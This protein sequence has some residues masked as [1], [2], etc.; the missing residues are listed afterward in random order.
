[1]SAFFCYRNEP[2]IVDEPFRSTSLSLPP[3]RGRADR[4]GIGDM[5]LLTRRCGE[6]N[7]RPEA[8]YEWFLMWCG[9]AI[10][11]TIHTVTQSNPHRR[12]PL[13]RCSSQERQQG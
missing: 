5:K 13:T 2:P 12:R 10:T 3:S 1:M 6:T 4:H 7:E 11:S 9:R 8:A